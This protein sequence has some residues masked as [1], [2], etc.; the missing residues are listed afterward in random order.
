MSDSIVPPAE[1][2]QSGFVMQTLSVSI[3][4]KFSE[5]ISWLNRIEG[6]QPIMHVGNLEI[7]K[8]DDPLGSN[9]VTCEIGTM[10][11]VKKPGQ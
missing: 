10:I 3:A 9:S 8:R 1:T 5:L 4:L 6:N 7:S 11:P 2:E